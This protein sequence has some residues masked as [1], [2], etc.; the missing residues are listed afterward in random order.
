MVLALLGL[1]S[2]ASTRGA[3]REIPAGSGWVCGARGDG[4]NF[5]VRHEADCTNAAKA[6]APHDV[7]YCFTYLGA[8]SA[9]HHS[10]KPTVNECDEQS[11]RFARDEREV[12]RCEER[13]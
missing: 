1:A 13:H 9:S 5:C 8:D 3:P 7:A 10:C 11:L 2:C 6:C 4:T 12:S